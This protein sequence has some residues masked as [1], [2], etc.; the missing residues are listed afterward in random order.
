M[1]LI[2]VGN[3]PIRSNQGHLINLF[4]YVVRLSSHKIKGF[5]HLVGSKTDAVSVARVENLDPLPPKVWIGNPFGINTIPEQ[6]LRDAYPNG[7][8]LN[9]GEVVQ[10]TY[11]MGFNVND[12]PHPTLGLLTVMMAIEYGKYFYDSVTITGIEGWHEGQPTYYYNDTPAKKIPP[13]LHD[14]NKERDILKHL[15]NQNKIKLLEPT[16]VRFLEAYP[17]GPKGRDK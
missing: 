16:D 8:I 3:A 4:D 14:Y 7:V 2:V 1:R 12:G 5:E 10:Q 13:H 15:I 9:S 6:A 17:W 11:D